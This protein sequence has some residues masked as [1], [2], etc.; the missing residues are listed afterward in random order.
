MVTVSGKVSLLGEVFGSLFELDK[1]VTVFYAHEEA[2]VDVSTL[3][4]GDIVTVTGKF[5]AP[6]MIYALGIEKT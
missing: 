6:D 1:T 2:T 3:K 4:N 5:V